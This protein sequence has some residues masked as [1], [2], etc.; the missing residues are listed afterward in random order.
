MSDR[1]ERFLNGREDEFLLSNLTA[2]E[3]ASLVA[4]R[5]RTRDFT[6]DEARVALASFEAWIRLS[7]RSVEVSTADVSAAIGFLQRLDL[8][9]RTLDAIHIALAQRVDATLVTFDRQMATSARAL[10][11]GVATP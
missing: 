6:V 5:V 1:A 7:I 11:A 2:A 9:L 3:F 8:P 4:R 10:G